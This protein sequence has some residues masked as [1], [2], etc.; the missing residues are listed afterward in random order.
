MNAITGRVLINIG[1]Q[2]VSLVHPVSVIYDDNGVFLS[3]FNTRSFNHEIFAVEFFK[4]RI[5]NSFKDLL[6]EY[7][8]GKI[9]NI[10]Q[11]DYH[12]FDSKIITSQQK[13][14]FPLGISYMTPFTS[15]KGLTRRN[16]LI[17]TL[18]NQIYSLDRKLVSTRRPKATLTPEQAQYSFESTSELPYKYHLPIT[19]LSVL[20][21]KKRYFDLRKIKVVP[22]ELES[23]SMMLAYGQDLYFD[24]I[25]PQKVLFLS[26]PASNINVQ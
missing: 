8:T 19:G 3:Y 24:F 1:L 5:E 10:T 6:Y 15:K 22:T 9:Q 2:D 20:T 11:N 7:Y 13:F 4:D 26:C 16:F 14:A 17:I 25:S 21:G 23:T 18:T 12:Q